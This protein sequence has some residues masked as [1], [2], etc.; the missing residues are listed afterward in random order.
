MS[1]YVFVWYFEK[2]GTVLKFSKKKV[3]MHGLNTRQKNFFRQVSNARNAATVH[4]NLKI[5]QE[6]TQ[7]LKKAILKKKM[8]LWMYGLTQV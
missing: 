5:Q 3:P 7:T 8:I 2:I 1:R 4:R 6:L